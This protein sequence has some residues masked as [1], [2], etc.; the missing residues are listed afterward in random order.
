MFTVHL[1][2]ASSD[3]DWQQN[4]AEDAA[5]HEQCGFAAGDGDSTRTRCLQKRSAPAAPA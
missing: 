1:M 5:V 4:E 3:F 2:M